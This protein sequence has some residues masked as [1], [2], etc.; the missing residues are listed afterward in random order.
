MATHVLLDNITHKDL[1]IIT[2][3]S[4]ALGDNI[5]LTGVFPTE[6]R[7]AQSHYPLFFNKNNQTGQFAPVALLGFDQNENLF[8]TPEGWQADYLPLTVKRQPFLIG[9]QNDS[10]TGEQNAVVHLDIEHPR[11]S[12]SEG[13]AVFL[14]FGG[15]SPF[16][17]QINSILLAIHQGHEYNQSFIPCLTALEL[18]EPVSLDI[19][20]DNGN[21]HKLAGLYTINEQQLNK[22][23]AESLKQ[24]QQQGFLAHIYMLIASL[25]NLPKLIAIKNRQLT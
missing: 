12:N 1:R 7:Q 9:F 20:L 5:N 24:L 17:E 14:E 19:E 23:P 21:K 25:A 16:L 11:I 2:K 15:N 13:E 4:A 22:L 18:I 3:R 8:L 6:F 10:Q